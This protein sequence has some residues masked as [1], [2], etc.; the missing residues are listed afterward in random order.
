[1]SKSKTRIKNKLREKN[2]TTTQTMKLNEMKL[3][4][5]I[6]ANIEPIELFYRIIQSNSQ[7]IHNINIQM[8]TFHP[9]RSL[10]EGNRKQIFK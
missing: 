5:S 9:K 10:Q 7:F 4:R 6:D 2:K 1:M 8:T 3:N